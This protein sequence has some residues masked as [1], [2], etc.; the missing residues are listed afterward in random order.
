MSVG[1]KVKDASAVA[2]CS[3]RATMS[4]KCGKRDSAKQKKKAS[5]AMTTT[6]TTEFRMS[7]P[8]QKPSSVSSNGSAKG[9]KAGLMGI[10][11][12]RLQSATC[13]V[14][15]MAPMS[16]WRPNR[17]MYDSTCCGSDCKST[18]GAIGIDH[19]DCVKLSSPTSRRGC[20]SRVSTS[21]RSV[22]AL[23]LRRIRTR[24][25]TPTVALPSV[26]LPRPSKRR[27]RFEKYKTLPT[28]ITGRIVDPPRVAP[29][30]ASSGT[31]S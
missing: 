26:L 27:R 10:P 2:G 18:R 13:I 19:T 21:P 1:S 20:S 14:A 30:A 16:S 31:A 23:S 29:T 15:A 11:R 12:S 4:A 17:A 9:Y 25:S 3:M 28:R 6:T 7:A 24:Y 5:V 22:K 8:R